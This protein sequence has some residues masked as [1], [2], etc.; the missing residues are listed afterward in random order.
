MTAAVGLYLNA[1]FL[2]KFGRTS[3]SGVVFAVVGLVTDTITL[4]LPATVMV[5]WQRSRRGLALTGCGMYA[6]AVA[7]TLLTAVGFAATNIDDAVAGRD[8]ASARRATLH[9]DIVRLK[10][11]RTG[12]VFAPIEPGAVAAAQIG[13]DQECGRVGPNCRQRVAELNAVLRDKAAA[14]RAAEIDA[15]IVTQEASLNAL[16]A[17]A[18]PDP[19]T[20]AARA[21]VMW[22]SGGHVAASSEDIRMTRVLGIAAVLFMAGLL[23]AFGTALRQPVPK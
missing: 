13:R 23:L 3:E 20:E 8:A 7:M 14:D 12:L 19:Q 9:D 22:L 17:L 16:P 2:W 6:I 18:S 5:L 1:S 21:A 15:R 4:V 11:E 10:S